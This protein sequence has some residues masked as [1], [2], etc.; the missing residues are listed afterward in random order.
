MKNW[1]KNK[2]KINL[3]IDAI[4]FVVITAVAGL[5]FLMKYVLL[6]G[7]KI[8]DLYDTGT[9]LFFWGLDRH[10]WGAIHL[11]LALF[12]VFL[13]ILHI[14]LHWGTIV[15]VFQQMFAV[16]VNRYVISIFIGVLAL[17]LALAPL[18]IKPAVAQSER[19]H[20]RNRT[21][22]R[23]MAIPGYIQQN[24]KAENETEAEKYIHEIPDQNVQDKSVS[25]NQEDVNNESDLLHRHHHA[26]I[27]IDGSMTVNEISAKYNVSVEEMATAINIPVDCANERLGRLKRR[28]GFEIDDLR[29][30]VL[31]KLP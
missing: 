26:Q 29:V 21:P 1:R 31:N 27:D 7:Y 18:I 14:I 24:E 11:Y 25:E 8:N 13:L 12:L 23:A 6:P 4:M 20:N 30:F 17:F 28:Y 9:E 3:V 16:K 10:Q 5:G 15:S 22:E 2:S 19:K